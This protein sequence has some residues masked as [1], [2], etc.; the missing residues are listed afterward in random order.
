MAVKEA[1]L[2]FLPAVGAGLPQADG[3]CSCWNWERWASAH[4]RPLGGEVAR[5]Q[6]DTWCVH[7]AVNVLGA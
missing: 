4:A 6:L 1:L 3:G 7:T 5:H 2:P